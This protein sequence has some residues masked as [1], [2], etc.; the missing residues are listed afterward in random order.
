MISDTYHVQEKVLAEMPAPCRVI[1]DSINAA[2]LEDYANTIEHLKVDHLN[3]Q[4]KMLTMKANNKKMKQNRGQHNEKLKNMAESGVSYSF[5]TYTQGEKKNLI[6]KR[7]IYGI[8]NI[9]FDK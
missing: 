9:L 3:A 4:I 7:N 2:M 6:L 5:G 8:S 1:L